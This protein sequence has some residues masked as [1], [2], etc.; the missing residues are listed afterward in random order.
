MEKEKQN[1]K[2]TKIIIGSVVA[3]LIIGCGIISYLYLSKSTTTKTKKLYSPYELSGNNLEKFDLQFLKLENEEKNKAYS[4]LSIKYALEMLAEGADGSSKEQLD[5]VIGKYKARK[6][7]NNKNMSLANAIFIKNDYMI[8]TLFITDVMKNGSY[9]LFNDKAKHILED[10][11]N[12]ENLTQGYYL[13]GV[14]SR[15]KQIL[16]PIIEVLERR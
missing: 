12:I 13:D 1:K 5:S 9:I 6:Y 15:K 14:V 3:L 7:E 11:F 16:P 10:S 4:P 8:V 2:S